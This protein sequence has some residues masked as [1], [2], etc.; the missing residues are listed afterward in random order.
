MTSAQPAGYRN[1]A[2]VSSETSNDYSGPHE[3]LHLLLN[4]GH[5]E[6]Y[7]V[8]WTEFNDSKMLWS[9]T[10]KRNRI[11]DTKRIS[12]TQEKVILANPLAK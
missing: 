10:E 8:Y 5:G 3:L 2:L 9:P 4:E 1:R 7:L 11:T 12:K 6:G